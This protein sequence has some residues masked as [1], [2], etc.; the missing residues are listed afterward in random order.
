MGVH[1]W[2]LRART[3]TTPLSLAR[4]VDTTPAR[5]SSFRRVQRKNYLETYAATLRHLR[6][7][8][9]ED[10]AMDLIVGGQSKTIGVLEHSVLVTLGLRPTDTVVDVGCGSGRL[11][12]RLAPVHPGLYVGTDILEDLV[13][14]AEKKAARPEW[15]F[16]AVQHPP[17]PL[18]EGTVDFVCFFS[19]FTH[20]LDEDIYRYL[21]DAAR[22]LK[23]GGRIIFS[24]LDFSVVSHWAIFDVT[25]RDTNPDA[26]LNKFINKDAINVWA[27]HLNLQVDALHD[28]PHDWIQLLEDIQ[29]SDGRTCSGLTHFG[30]SVGILSRPA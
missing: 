8:H 18:G 17:L 25:L 23:P 22:L 24:Y 6:A 11:S 9:G 2:F 1:S 28:G 30:Q 10:A 13:R 19:V 29:Y 7:A 20:L 3:R 12:S 15:R 16:H 21:A 26:V 14:Y 5:A 27:R 4:V